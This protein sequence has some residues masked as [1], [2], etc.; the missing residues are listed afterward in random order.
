MYRCN[1]NLHNLIFF[2][3]NNDSEVFTRLFILLNK[4]QVIIKNWKKYSS[5]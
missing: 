1:L 5:S 2:M 4:D 3:Y